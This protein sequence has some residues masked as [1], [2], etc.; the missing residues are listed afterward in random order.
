M[1]AMELPRLDGKTSSAA[2]VS[3]LL[4]SHSVT[5][6]SHYGIGRLYNYAM[7]MCSL[8]ILQIR[9]HN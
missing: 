9:N 2:D 3:A 7:R 4:A 5:G 6:I 8:I 1:G